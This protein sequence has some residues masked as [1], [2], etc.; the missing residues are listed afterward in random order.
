[1][2][3][4]CCPTP[5]EAPQVACAPLLF[6]SDAGP[7]VPSAL[8]RRLNASDTTFTVSDPCHPI[9]PWHGKLT[10]GERF[11]RPNA[12]V[13]GDS[14]WGAACTAI[15]TCVPL[16]PALMRERQY[17][18]LWACCPSWIPLELFHSVA[19]VRG[20]RRVAGSVDS[21]TFLAAGSIALRDCRHS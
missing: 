19:R 21:N 11:Q 2:F 16:R 1:M 20:C 8:R 15:E 5:N 17:A 18:F 9:W 14:S 12:D 4:P 10:P 7:P 6:A 3:V 13:R